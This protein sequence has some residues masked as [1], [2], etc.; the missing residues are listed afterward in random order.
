M[1]PLVLPDPISPP[2]PHSPEERGA[3]KRDDDDDDDAEGRAGGEA[4][5]SIK[6]RGGMSRFVATRRLLAAFLLLPLLLAQLPAVGAQWVDDT[7][8]YLGTAPLPLRIT[9]TADWDN[10]M[11]TGLIGTWANRSGLVWYCQGGPDDRGA[12]SGSLLYAPCWTS[13]E[14]PSPIVSTI[15]ADLNRDGALDILVQCEDGGLYVVNGRHRNETPT[16]IARG[17]VPHFNA[18]VPQV[19][20]VTVFSHCGLPEIA[21]VDAAGSLVVLRATT[22]TTAD[23]ECAGQDAPPTFTPSVLVAGAEGVREVVPLGVISD[24]IDGDCVVDLLY[25]VHTRE[26]DTLD[27]YAYFPARAEHA[28]LLTLTPASRYGFPAVADVSGDGAPDLLF[29]LCASQEDVSTAFGACTR[30]DGVVVFYNDLRGSPP[31][32]SGGCCSGHPFG[33][34]EGASREFFLHKQNACGV[35][36]RLGRPLA[37]TSSLAS[38][39]LL[40]CGDYNRDGYVDLLVPSTYGPLLLTAQRDARGPP[41]ACAPLDEARAG[42]AGGDAAAYTAA[43]PFF[44]IIAGDGVLSVVLTFHDASPLPVAFYAN[45]MPRLR[46]NY[47]LASSALNGVAAVHDWGVY[48]PGAVHR[49]GWS[50]VTMRQRWAYAAQLS[51]TQGHAL[52]PARLL[53]GLDRTFSYIQGYAVGILVDRQPVRRAWSATLVPNSNVFVWLNPLLAQ[54]SWRLR[55]YLVSATYERLL[56]VVL[57]TSLT[58]LAVPIVFLKWREVQHDRREWKLR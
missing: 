30:F 10:G 16:E 13:A 7:A 39:L 31:C 5:A 14:F 3:K 34:H 4:A 20:L 21:L 44:A 56:V 54:G 24:D 33:F 36:T 28:L 25:T 38:P 47:F 50:D 42:A 9:A 11:K 19:S 18:L 48:Q 46:E 43:I 57:V 12:G 55:L 27:V 58:L 37:M 41:F 53:F 15:V 2:L 35:P 8:T 40:R 1:L 52:Q 32:G 45:R 17:T 51:R 22:A 29:P 26:S 23:A 6:C 49:F